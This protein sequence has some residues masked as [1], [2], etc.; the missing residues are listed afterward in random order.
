MSEKGKEIIEM[1]AASV[2]KM[3]YERKNYALGV[4]EGMAIMAQ[5]QQQ[6]PPA[7]RPGA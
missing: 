1:L 5:A 7:D 6:K 3:D 4:L 2:Q